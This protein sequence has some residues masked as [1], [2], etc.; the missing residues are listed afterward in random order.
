MFHRAP[1]ESGFTIIDNHP[2]RDGRLSLAARGLL[3][4]LLSLPD[5]W[6]FSEAGLIKILPDGRRRVHGAIAEL[7]QAGYIVRSGQQ[8]DGKGRLLSQIWD[9]YET[10]QLMPDA[11]NAQADATT[12]TQNVQADASRENADNP[13]ATADVR[14]VQAG[15]NGE[16]A[17]LPQLA[18]DVRYQRAENVQESNK[19]V[20]SNDYQERTSST[21]KADD[22]VA[23]VIEYMNEVMQTSFTADGQ[24]CDNLRKVLSE[25]VSAEYCKRAFQTCICSWSE[26][27]RPSINPRTVYKP[28]KVGQYIQAWRP[29][30]ESKTEKSRAGRFEE[31]NRPAAQRIT[32]EPNASGTTPTCPKCGSSSDV[33]PTGGG[34]FTCSCGTAWRAG[35]AS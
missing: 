18:T 8:R 34:L 25:G 32:Y 30:Y 28:D 16:D 21:T 23:A 29:E 7:E 1:H 35:R 27:A 24:E 5:D 19:E 13:E 20:S 6:Q 10:P 3:S 2:L 11:R 14:S 17:P 15:A 31:Y 12:D 22:D 9:I 33:Q 4:T 26:A